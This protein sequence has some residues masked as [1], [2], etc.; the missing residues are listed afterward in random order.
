MEFPVLTGRRALTEL[1]VLTEFPV[2]TERRILTE[3]PALT[4]CRA[5]TWKNIFLTLKRL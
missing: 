2:M 5:L 3:F 4:E 1:L